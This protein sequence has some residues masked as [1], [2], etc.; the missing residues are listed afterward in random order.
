CGSA[1][2]GCRA[3]SADGAA[4]RCARDRVTVLVMATESARMNS[5]AEARFRIPAHPTG[6]HVNVIDLDTAADA[7][8]ARLVDQMPD[9]D[10]VVMIVSAGG[11]AHT[12]ATI[13]RAWR[14]QRGM[15]NAS[16]VRA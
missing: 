10:L 16:V 4:R 2:Q 1:V 11:D 15:K 5:A 12:A 7:D 6:R 9:A 3:R 8:V 14:R 13:G